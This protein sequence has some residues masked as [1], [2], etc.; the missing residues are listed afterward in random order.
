LPDI[1]ATGECLIE[2]YSHESLD[3]AKTFYTTVAGD[4]ANVLLMVSKL[5]TSCGF[6]TRA[7]DDPFGDH[8]VKNLQQHDIDTSTVKRV[9]GFTGLSFISLLPDGD[10]EF[11]YYRRGSAASTIVPEDLDPDYIGD[12][13]ILH[14]SAI[15]PATSQNARATVLRAVEIARDRGVTVSYDTNLR[16]GLWSAEE[17]RT[18]LF[19]V[20]PFTDIVLPGY[21]E[22]TKA[23]LGVDSP[24]EAIE[25]LQAEG[26]AVVAVKCGSEGAYVSTP[27]GV[28]KIPAVVPY[29]V[30]DTTGAGDA[31]VGAFLHCL[32]KGMDELEGAR[33]GV[34]A[35]GLKVAG[36]GASDSQPTLKRVEEHLD[37]GQVQMV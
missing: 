20:L 9:P 33:W 16:L 19:E 29:G 11:V 17:A 27:R 34:V 25:V 12:A 30:A 1:V 28:A 37:L 5:G 31:F 4:T 13:K 18:S 15:L 6:I 10:R 21:P 7:A 14:A 22:E 24:V 2:L 36:R 8:V 23:L 26:A 35:A 32:V 3:T